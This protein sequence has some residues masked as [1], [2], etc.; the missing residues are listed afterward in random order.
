LHFTANLF[1]H[2]RS[3]SVS[4]TNET[5]IL[6]NLSV[7]KLLRRGFIWEVLRARSMISYQ[8]NLKM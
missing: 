2:F 3:P 5:L 1:M 6:L 4:L 8:L 7:T